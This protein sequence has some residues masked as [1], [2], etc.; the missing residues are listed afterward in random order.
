MARRFRGESVHKVDQKGRVSIPAAFRRVLQDCDP[1]WTDGLSPNLVI[2]Y[3]DSTRRFLEA[4][5]MTAMED[6]D[7]KIEAMPRGTRERRMLERMF[8]GQAAP[9]QVDDTGRIVLSQKMRD[10]IAIADEALFIASGDTFQIWKP[11][12]YEAQALKF[13]DFADEFPEGFDP[14]SLLDASHE[15]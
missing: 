4:Y 2:V 3:G 13:E 1:E 10:K 9:M 12:T 8:S 7:R 15:G 11:E 14:L 5:S 6:V